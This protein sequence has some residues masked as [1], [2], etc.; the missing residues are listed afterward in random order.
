MEFHCNIFNGVFDLNCL[1]VVKVDSVLSAIKNGKWKERI[2]YFRTLKDKVEIKKYKESLPCVTF[3]GVFETKREDAFCVHYNQL[4][5]V[6]IDKIGETRLK[7]LKSE[8]K[9]NIHV[10]AFF[11]SPSRGLKILVPVDADL[12]KHNTDTFYCVEQMFMDMYNIKIDKTGKNVSRLCFVSHDPELY[13]NPNC[14]FLP[15]EA[16]F[17]REGYETIQSHKETFIPSVDADYIFDTCVKMVKKSKVGRYQKGNRNNYIFVLSCLM[18][19]FGVN[20]DQSLALIY[21]RYNTLE[22]REVR[23]TVASAFRKN[24]AKFATKI[25][26]QRIDTNQVNIEL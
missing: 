23:S 16:N 17:R 26:N 1:N 10:Y 7:S 24:K 22:F 8:L 15:I 19:E 20:F 11:E 14:F 21:A 25:I 18:N 13:Y 6:D 5:I 3:P 4:M 12:S 2:E 9:T